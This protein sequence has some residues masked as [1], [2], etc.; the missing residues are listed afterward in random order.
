MPRAPGVERRHDG[1]KAEH[2]VGPGDDMATISETDIVVLAPLISM[3]E[4]NHRFAKRP[5]A[6][7]QHKTRKF[8]ATAYSTR[9]AQV[10]ALRR[11]RLE[12]RFLGLANGR[13]IA[14]ATGRR[15]RKVLRQGCVRA[16]QFPPGGKHGGVEQKSAA[17]L[18]RESIHEVDRYMKTGGSPDRGCYCGSVCPTTLKI[19]VRRGHTSVTPG[20]ILA[21]VDAEALAAVLRIIRN[22]A[23]GPVA[24]V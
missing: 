4:I 5:A 12:E 3:P 8:E 21:S 20:L 9:L 11:F 13:F 7:R 19:G 18:L 24:D 15:G 16:G 1:A 22:V 14:I 10:T 6:S 17:R 23:N 2:A